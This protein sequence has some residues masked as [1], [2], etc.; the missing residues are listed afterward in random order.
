[1]LGVVGQQCYV[2]LHGAF[3]VTSCPQNCNELNVRDYSEIY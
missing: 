1:M 2:R 3:S